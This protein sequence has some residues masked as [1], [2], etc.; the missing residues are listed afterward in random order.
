MKSRKYKL[1]VFSLFISVPN[2]DFLTIRVYVFYRITQAIYIRAYATIFIRQRVYARP[3][4][5]CRVIQTCAIVVQVKTQRMVKF[6]AVVL[7]GL[8]TGIRADITVDA[9]KRVVLR[10][11]LHRA[12]LTDHRAVVAEVVLQIVME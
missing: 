12:I 5:K 1:T 4:Y 8:E 11:L 10:G 6:L 7:I 3:Y 2:N 9:A